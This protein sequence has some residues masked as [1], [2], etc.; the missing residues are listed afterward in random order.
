MWPSSPQLIPVLFNPKRKM[1]MQRIP[2]QVFW[3]IIF[4]SFFLTACERGGGSENRLDISN[5]NNADAGNSSTPSSNTEEVNRQDSC[6]NIAKKE[7]FQKLLDLTNTERQKQGLNNLTLV[8]ELTQ[9]AQN[10][11]EDMAQN[12]YFSHTGLNGSSVGDRAKAVGYNWNYVGENLALGYQSATSVI[13]GWMNSPGHRENILDPNY[14]EIGF[15]F[16]RQRNSEDNY[17]VQVFGK[18]D[19]PATQGGTPLS[20]STAFDQA[21]ACIFTSNPNQSVLGVQ[22]SQN[23]STNKS[24]PVPEPSTIMGLIMLSASGVLFT[25]S[26]QQ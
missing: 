11:A 7:L 9:A 2:K 23:T 26:R 6:V 19:N 21:S 24:K 4:F 20:S 8:L 14:T 22:L 1:L 17:W 13:Q 15:G 12:N 18:P 3:S 16:S 10:H 25:V 5:I